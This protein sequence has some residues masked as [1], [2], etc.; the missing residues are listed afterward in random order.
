MIENDLQ[1]L[2]MLSDERKSNGAGQN[3]TKDRCGS[4]KTGV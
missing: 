2:I 1:V 3:I 4:C